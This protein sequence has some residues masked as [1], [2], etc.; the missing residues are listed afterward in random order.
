MFG[1][2]NGARVVATVVICMGLLIVWPYLFGGYKKKSKKDSPVQT[3]TADAGLGDAEVADAQ[4]T[5]IDGAVLG[6]GG[7]APAVVV[8]PVT[9]VAPL[10]KPVQPKLVA[11]AEKSIPLETDLVKATISNFG[12]A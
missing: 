4:V 8:Q 2:G 7:V 5:V 9:P 10:D 11:E 1:Q 6:D 12:G 3:V